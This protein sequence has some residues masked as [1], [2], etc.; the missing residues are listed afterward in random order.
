MPVC[1]LIA[2]YEALVL[3]SPFMCRFLLG[4]REAKQTHIGGWTE[5]NEVLPAVC[6]G[7][8]SIFIVHVL[9]VDACSLLSGTSARP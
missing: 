2:S 8:L 4:D 1:C 9:L 6:S 5:C 7:F 3:H